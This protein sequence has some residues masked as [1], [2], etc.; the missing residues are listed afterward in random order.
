MDALMLGLEIT[1][2]VLDIA[3]IVIVARS[4]IRMKGRK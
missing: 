2:I 4:L 1:S 3:V